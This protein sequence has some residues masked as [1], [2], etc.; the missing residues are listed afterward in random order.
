MFQDS[1]EQSRAL[2]FNPFA[3]ESGQGTLAN[4]EDPD[5]ILHKALFHH[6]LHCLLR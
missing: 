1:G 2:L 6:D 5:E 4:S 3:L